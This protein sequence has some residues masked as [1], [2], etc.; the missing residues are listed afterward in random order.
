MG[1][2]ENAAAESAFLLAPQ[3]LLLRASLEIGQGDSLDAS[4]YRFYA[5][6]PVRNT[7]LIAIEQGIV[8]VSGGQEIESGMG[9]FMVR[10]R[11][12]VAGHSRA[13]WLL[14]YLG[15]GTGEQRFFPYSSRSIDFNLSAAFT[16]SLGALDL[17][18]AAGLVWAQR[19][20]DELAGQ[21][22]DYKRLTAGAGLRLGPRF[23]VR[24][25]AITQLYSRLDK[26]RDLI[27]AGTGYRWG[28]S[29]GVFFEGQVET[30]P[31]AD[32]VSNWAATAGLS[33][34]F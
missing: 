21:H 29:M 26:R 31:V 5:A 14:G 33:V 10:G 24:A 32:R 18:A 20:P 8:A 30:G 9:D 34:R 16:D 17:F 25:G 1:V 19:V 22:D 15:T 12:R 3:R 11:A 7:F 2:Y 6:F 4:V 23:A 27:F 28:E 13:L